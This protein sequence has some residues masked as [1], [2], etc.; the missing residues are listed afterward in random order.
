[1]TEPLAQTVRDA[2]VGLWERRYSSVDLVSATLE[3]IAENE[4]LVHAYARVLAD[5][6]LR[7]AEEADR[8]L[9]RGHW[10][11]PLHGIPVGVKDLC[12]T[13]GIPTEGGSRVLAGHVPEYDATVVT[14]LQEAGAVIV[15]KTVTHEFAYGQ[16]IPPTRNPWNP[17]MYPGGSSAGSGV[18]VAVG[19]ALG[20]IGT[21]TGGSIR[22]PASINGIVGLK[23]TFGRVSRYG[24]LALSPSLDHVG[25]MARTVEDC[26]LLLAAIAGHD[27]SDPASAHQPVPDYQR[28]LHAGVRGL[29][30]G[31]VLD[32]YFGDHVDPE[33]RA[34]VEAAQAELRKQGA[35]L[36]PISLPQLGLSVVIGMTILQ[37]EAS[38][39]HR[40]LL[41]DHVGD[42]EP[43]TRLMLEFGNLLPATHY[44]RALRARRWLT[45]AVRDAFRT[46][47][48]DAMLSPTLPVPTVL[49]E[50]SVGDFLG[51]TEQ[52]IDLSKLLAHGIP[53]NVTGLPTLTLPC[54]FTSEGLPV[55]L[56]VMAP[57]FE[58]GM[59]FRVGQAYE[60]ATSWHEMRPVVVDTKQE[61]GNRTPSPAGG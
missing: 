3:R 47:R 50:Q 56:Q 33:I 41:R 21:D 36:V 49:R 48:L 55:G 35:N 9:R 5:E 57:P 22:V 30:F 52:R 17:A 44:A 1:M 53:S 15:G 6:A 61:E 37:A 23:P 32:H 59:A 39:I 27:P 28:E 60:A 19:T 46:Y 43:G 25:P 51:G 20:A 11:G 14:R 16:N 26:A 8:E 34:L 24:V 45:E 54:G 40:E 2:S 18:A 12:Y 58:E 13:R 31:V 7:S 10:R 42:Y 4:P 29:R 38:A